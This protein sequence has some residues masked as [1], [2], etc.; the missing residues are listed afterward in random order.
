MRVWP[1][2]AVVVVLATGLPLAAQVKVGVQSLDEQLDKVST[3]LNE[4]SQ[5]YRAAAEKRRDLQAVSQQADA[6]LLRDRK[7]LAEVKQT[8]EEEHGKSAAVLAARELAEVARQE[9][10]EARD[11]VVEKQ[12]QQSGYQAAAKAH[13]DNLSRQKQ[14]LD[15]KIDAATRRE[16]ARQ[17]S[18]SANRLRSLEDAAIANDPAAR[19]AKQRS[20]AADKQLAATVGQSKDAVEKDSRLA[21]AKLGFVRSAQQ[22]KAAKQEVA[23]LDQ[24]M[25]PMARSIQ[26]LLNEQS[27]LMQ[28]MRL[29]NNGAGVAARNSNGQSNTRQYHSQ[30]CSKCQFWVS[31]TAEPGQ[32]CPFCGVTW[33]GRTTK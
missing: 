9:S 14:S 5:I 16:A 6:E 33:G 30:Q 3:T 18:E 12:K 31:V 27:K 22:A 24:K 11:Q 2:V 4:Q 19:A 23:K 28:R 8:V 7:A 32:R 26:S 29:Q 10:S 20:Q 13:A 21:S 15:A 1:I 17:L 25:A